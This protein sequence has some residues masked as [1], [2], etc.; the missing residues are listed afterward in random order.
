[1]QWLKMKA[2]FK[3]TL[4]QTSQQRA[5]RDECNL[6]KVW[7]VA[8]YRGDIESSQSHKPLSDQQG[9]KPIRSAARPRHFGAYPNAF[10]V[11]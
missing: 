7:A 5:L 4:L 3:D 2:S 6:L 9:P 8:T 10:L 11:E 1:M